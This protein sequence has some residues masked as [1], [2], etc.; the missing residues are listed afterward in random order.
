MKKILLM[1]FATAASLPVLAAET[2]AD[3]A[4]ELSGA[5]LSPLWALPFLGMILSIAIFPLVLPDF[6]GKHYGKVSLAWALI[7]LI[8]LSFA[9]GISVSAH[10]LILVMFEQFLPFILLLL[11]LFTITGGIK[12]KGQLAG[13]PTIN[14]AILFVGAILA[15]VL[16]TTGA[17]VLLIRP[18]LSANEWRKHK[19]HTILFFIFIVGNIGGTLTP[20]GNPPVLMGFISKIPFFWPTVNLFAP[21]ALATVIL[22]VM[23]FIVDTILHKRETATPPPSST[24]IS[25]GGKWNFLLLIGV[26]AAVMVSSMDLGVAFTL[27]YVHMPVGTLLELIAFGL[28]TYLSVRITS[29]AVRESNNFTWHPI[30]EVGKIFAAIFVCMAPLIAML[31]A[32]ADGPMSFII[33]SLSS[34]DG[35]PLNGMYYWLSG[36]LSAFLDSAPAYL[37]FFNTA[38]APAAAAGMEPNIF[39]LNVLPNTLIAITVGASF[40]GAISYIGN[41]PNMMIKAIAEENGIKMPSFFGY[42]GWAILVLVPVF[43]IIQYIFIS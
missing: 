2:A 22:L 42:V 30:L 32:G 37:V 20:L 16:G 33:Q 25:F 39:M 19:L 36:G 13:S 18:L 38:A 43:L 26:V 1:L 24:S 7:V 11:S 34:S 35:T 10:S 9:Q 31:R 6:W 5:T 28:I 12:L 21:T 17:A 15:S 8:G 27:H 4:P 14:T 23:Y 40:M 41:A 3:H 29:K